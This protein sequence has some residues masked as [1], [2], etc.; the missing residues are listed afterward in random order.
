MKEVHL[1]RHYDAV[2]VVGTGF[3][4]HEDD[5]LDIWGKN[6]LAKA[7]LAFDNR[8]A[9]YIILTGLLKH[10]SGV[11]FIDKTREVTKTLS[12]DQKLVLSVQAESNFTIDSE[13]DIDQA[14]FVARQYGFRSLLF[15][16]ETPHWWRL[17]YLVH[18]RAPD[19]KVALLKSM[20]A[21]WWYYT[22]VA[23]DIHMK[24]VG[25]DE[26]GKIVLG[27]MA[28]KADP[29]FEKYTGYLPQIKFGEFS[30]QEKQKKQG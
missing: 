4:S 2:V 21:P 23:G 7:V 16:T 14:I 18:K 13:G 17:K 15:A 29:N 9:Y 11:T 10:D 26:M 22:F 24:I 20:S 30:G 3:R 27:P 1:N 6:R 19:L 8:S 5:S 12:I 25:Q 28:K